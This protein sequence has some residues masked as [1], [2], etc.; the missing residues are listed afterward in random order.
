MHEHVLMTNVD[1]VLST[2]QRTLN[3][4][5]LVMSTHVVS[6]VLCPLTDTLKQ[7]YVFSHSAVD[8]WR[9]LKCSAMSSCFATGV[10]P[11]AAPTN[12]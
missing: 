2:N 4:V 5:E 11:K 7:M 10:T 12:V 6:F 1:F 3:C 8:V 9:R